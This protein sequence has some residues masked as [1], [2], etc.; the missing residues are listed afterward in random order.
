LQRSCAILLLA[1]FSFSLIGP[2]A[3]VDKDSSLPACCR[4]GGK[5]HCAS[6]EQAHRQQPPSGPAVKAVRQ[7]TNFPQTDGVRAFSNSI[8]VSMSQSFFASIVSH[9][10]VHPQTEARQRVSFS[11]SCQ[12]RGPPISLS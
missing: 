5:H 7:C 9:P 12:K 3:F 10:S 2:E 11:R 6:M 8:L 4:R 1:F